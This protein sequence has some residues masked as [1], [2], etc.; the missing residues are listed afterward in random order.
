MMSTPSILVLIIFIASI[1]FEFYLNYSLF[2]MPLLAM[3]NINQNKLLTIFFT[4]CCCCLSSLY[5]SANS[6]QSD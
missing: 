4:S 5:E 6:R 1:V 2:V 3:I